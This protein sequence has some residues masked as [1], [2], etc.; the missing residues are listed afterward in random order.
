MMQLQQN[1]LYD[2]SKSAKSTAIPLLTLGILKVK[3]A[4]CYKY[5]GIVLQ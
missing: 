2:V 1:C 5:L 4:A 3:S